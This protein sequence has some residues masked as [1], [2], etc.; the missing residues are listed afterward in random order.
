MNQPRKLCNTCHSKAH[1]TDEHRPFYDD[2]SPERMAY[3]N[4]W[5]TVKTGAKFLRPKDESLATAFDLGV[6]EARQSG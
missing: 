5:E 2:S 1:D 6:S 3:L 4:G